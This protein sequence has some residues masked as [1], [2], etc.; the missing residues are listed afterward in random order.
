MVRVGL[1]PSSF[2]RLLTYV[3]SVTGHCFGRSSA[4]PVLDHVIT[5]TL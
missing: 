5:D 4:D 3:A 2:Q 1:N